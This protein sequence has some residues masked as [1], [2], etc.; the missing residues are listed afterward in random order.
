M[1]QKSP[2]LCQKSLETMLIEGNAGGGENKDASMRKYAQPMWRE[3]EREGKSALT[4]IHNLPRAP[5]D[6]SPFLTAAALCS[7]GGTSTFF[8]EFPIP[9]V[10]KS[11]PFARDTTEEAGWFHPTQPKFVLIRARARCSKREKIWKKS[12]YCQP[13]IRLDSVTGNRTQWSAYLIAYRSCS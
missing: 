10:A 4:I 13:R 8:S 2:M 11:A 12:I 7:S 1:T 9:I 6:F 3:R 5:N